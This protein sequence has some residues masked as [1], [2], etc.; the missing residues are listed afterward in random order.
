MDEVVRE[1]RLL[2]PPLDLRDI[3]PLLP[4]EILCL[5]EISEVLAGQGS[6]QINAIVP[7]TSFDVEI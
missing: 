7:A 2:L 6:M 4:L 5:L 1:A 3:R